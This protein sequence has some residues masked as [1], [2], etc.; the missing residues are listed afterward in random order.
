M[1]SMLV[2]ITEMQRNETMRHHV[3]PVRMAKNKLECQYA[4]AGNIT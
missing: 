2:A 3:T 4:A 1:C